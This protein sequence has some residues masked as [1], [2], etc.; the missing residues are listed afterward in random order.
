MYNVG[1]YFSGEFGSEE[2][3]G[4]LTSSYFTLGGNGYITFM[5][6]G[7]GNQDCLVKVEDKD[8]NI[9]AI[10]RNTLF[11]D[12]NTSHEGLTNEEKIK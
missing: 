2:H 8:G 12:F 1:K 4:T 9:L 5:L 7:A 3:K 11:A 10:Y 6:G